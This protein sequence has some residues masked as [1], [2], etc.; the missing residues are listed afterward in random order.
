MINPQKQHF[1]TH[2]K[3][4]NKDTVFYRCKTSISL[5]FS[6]EEISSDGA[7]LLLEKLERQHRLI[8]YFSSIIPDECNLSCAVHSIEKIVNATSI[9]VD[10]RL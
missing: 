4:R 1:L 2:P 6:T 10:A 7:V 8:H 5:D 3:I 9:D